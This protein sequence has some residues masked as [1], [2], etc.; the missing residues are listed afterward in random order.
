MILSDGQVAKIRERLESIKNRMGAFD[1][2][3]LIHAE[4]VIESNSKHAADILKILDE[5]SKKEDLI[6][7]ISRDIRER[8]GGFVLR[9]LDCGQIIYETSK[10]E[11]AKEIARE[12]A[13]L[14]GELKGFLDY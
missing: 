4:N 12:S 8:D 2:N 9:C 10:K 14:R 1:Q 11:D 6:A 13:K 3:Q 7:I 5:A